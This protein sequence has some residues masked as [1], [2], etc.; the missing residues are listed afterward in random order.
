[1]ALSPS[2]SF[3]ILC[4][5][6]SGLSEFEAEFQS[7]PLILHISHFSSSV[8]SKNNTNTSPKYTKKF[9]TEENRLEE[10]YIKATA[11]D[12]Q[13]HNLYKKLFSRS[14]QISGTFYSPSYNFDHQ[15]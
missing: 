14:S 1:M 8:R 3:S 10:W 12:T 5:F 7:T 9:L 6:R 15:R 4:F 2:A 11:S 13:R